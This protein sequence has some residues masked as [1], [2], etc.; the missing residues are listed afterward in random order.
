MPRKKNA[1]KP[2]EPIKVDFKPIIIDSLDVMAKHAIKDNN[3][4]KA[5]AYTKVI[6]QIK[7]ITTPIYTIED[8]NKLEIEGVG[9]SINELIIE[10]IATGELKAA[11]HIREDPA[12]ILFDN[13]TKIYGVG[14]VKAKELMNDKSIN[15]KSI[16]DL[17]KVLLTRPNLL[18]EKQIIGLKYIEDIQKRIPRAEVIDHDKL[19]ENAFKNI[20]SGFTTTVVGSYRRGLE[21]SGDIDVLVTNFPEN[22]QENKTTISDKDIQTYF[23]NVITSMKNSG[24]IT[25][26]LALGDKKCMAFVCI[27]PDKPARRLDILYTP[28]N[29]YPYALLY[30][31]GSDKFNIKFRRKTLEQGYSLSEHGLKKIN[32]DAKPLTIIQTEKDIFEFFNI[33]Y[34][35][36]INR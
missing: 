10:I 8:F 13:L 3:T 29:E 33:A 32:V 35:E 16:D 30:F 20:Y 28:P 34:V 6:G 9:K 4:F 15:I 36:P 18:N 21:S 5:R 14:P 12:T 7:T 31:T 25:D 24:Y 17:R 27:S 2:I 22:N 23:K 26:I 19:L 11:N 1:T